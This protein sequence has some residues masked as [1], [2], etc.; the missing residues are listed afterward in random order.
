MSTISGVA[1]A[2]KIAQGKKL[3]A[4]EQ[5][6]LNAQ[7]EESQRM[8][9]IWKKKQQAKQEF[10][11]GFQIELE[12]ENRVKA[13]LPEYDIQPNTGK[14]SMIGKRKV[15]SGEEIKARAEGSKKLG[16]MRQQSSAKANVAR[17]KHQAETG[18]NPKKIHKNL[19]QAAKLDPTSTAGINEAELV[20]K[21]EAVRASE[22]AVEKIAEGTKGASK[23]AADASSAVK[24]VAD[25]SKESAQ[26]AKKSGGVFSKISKFFKG[27]GGKIALIAAG[28]AALTA[29]AVWLYNKVTGSKSDDA[30]AE[31]AASAKTPEEAV[32]TKPDTPEKSE[33]AKPAAPAESEQTEP[34]KPE[35]ADPAKPAVPV[36]G[37]DKAED[38]KDKKV[39]DKDKAKSDEVEDKKGK[40]KEVPKDYVVKKGD[41]VWNIAKQHLKDLS[42]DP[43]YKPTDAEI[44]KHT[45]ELMELNQLEFE[46]D[47]YRVIIRP[48]DKL[49]LVA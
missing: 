34:E 33:P 46:P 14:P 45:K 25:A 18:V 37:D 35:E 6:F 19:K 12:K 36:K 17:A 20:A 30:A 15:V 7:K 9:S 5:A 31:K 1:L 42:S 3:T 2:D 26:V 28:V 11:R 27:K 23:G 43:N 39:E 49:K 44:L 13:G 8:Q 21:S 22:N 24:G 29:G 38:K 10:G 32:K 16:E 48:K 40:N 4:E 47:G 41:C